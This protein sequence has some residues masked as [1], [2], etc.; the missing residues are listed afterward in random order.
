MSPGPKRQTVGLLGS[1]NVTPRAPERT[2]LGRP[3]D[4]PEVRAYETGAARG[5]TG[6][7]SSDSESKSSTAMRRRSVS[8]PGNAITTEGAARSTMARSSAFGSRK[9]T[10]CGVAPSFQTPQQASMK[11]TP[12]GNPMVTRSPTL[13][14]NFSRA[15]AMRLVRASN[16]PQVRVVSP[17][18]TAG[19]SGIAW[20][21]R[22]NFSPKGI[23]SSGIFRY[24]S[25]S[26][27]STTNRRLR[28][29]A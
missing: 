6:R 3:V 20:A 19:A 22:N 26:F 21:R 12:L 13:M 8:R 29:I 4:P 24:K 10:G 25:L 27:R 23:M 1:A 9:D 17:Q 2:S 28:D 7:S 14:P 15:R 5:P 16:C 18:V 11:L